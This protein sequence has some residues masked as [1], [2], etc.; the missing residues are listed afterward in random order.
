MRDQQQ[1]CTGFGGH[2]YIA[3][4]TH[5]S[6]G[7]PAQKAETVNAPLT[8]VRIPMGFHV[9]YNEHGHFGSGKKWEKRQGPIDINML[10]IVN[11]G[12]G[13]LMPCFDVHGN[14][15]DSMRASLE[16]IAGDLDV[17]AYFNI[18]Q[19]MLSSEYALLLKDRQQGK[20]TNEQLK[21]RLLEVTHPNMDYLAAVKELG[22][23]IV[24]E[25]HD[26]VEKLKEAIVWC[27]YANSDGHESGLKNALLLDMH[28][29]PATLV[30][31][32]EG[33][34]VNVPEYIR[35]QCKRYDVKIPE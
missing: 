35:S 21:Q 24:P 11:L 34:T 9:D 30:L 25:L 29:E 31:K 7:I 33:L 16:V 2:G 18:G 23:K 26:R 15:S 4:V 32:G 14:T 27:L 10:D 6:L 5:I 19:E 12:R 28:K 8:T 22:V 20:L 13:A 1:G 3:T 17:A